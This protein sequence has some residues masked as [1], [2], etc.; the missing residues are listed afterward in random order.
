MHADESR[1]DGRVDELLEGCAALREDFVVLDTHLPAEKADDGAPVAGVGDDDV[2]AFAE[3]GPG[4]SGCLEEP[5][6][7]GERFGP[8]RGEE[9]VGR[10]ADREAGAGSQGLVEMDAKAVDRA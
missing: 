2:R 5:D 10:A 1:V 6:G 3:S 7:L 9:V 8:V 4:N